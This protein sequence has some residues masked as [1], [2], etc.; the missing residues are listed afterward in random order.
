MGGEILFVTGT[1]YYFNNEF[2]VSDIGLKLF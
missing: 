1:F 2:S